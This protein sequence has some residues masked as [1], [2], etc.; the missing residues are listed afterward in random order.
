MRDRIE[1]AF[2][3]W[4]H[5]AYRRAWRVIAIGALVTVA[6]AT[7]LPKLG[8]DTSTEGMFHP[9][10]PIR[11]AYDEFRARFGSDTMILAAVRP[12]RVFDLATLERLRALHEAIEAEVPLLV[13]VTSLVNARETRG[14]GDEL[15]VGELMEE[16]PETAEQVA[17]IERRALANPLYLDNL[18]SRDGRLTVVVIET[19]TYSSARDDAGFEDFGETG[20]PAA[21]PAFLT[22][23]EQSSIV[24][25]LEDVVRRHRAPG[26][27][28]HLAGTQV[29]ADAMQKEMQADMSRFTGLS[30]GMI[31]AFLA[32]LFRRLAGV[33][34]P[35]AAV[36]LSVVST[37]SI[38]AAIGVPITLPTQILPSFLLAV[39]V[40]ASVHILAI[41]F[42][43]RR[44]GE[45]KQAAIA[46]SLGHSGL[47][48]AMTSLTTAAGVASFVAADLRPISH[49]GW[50][51][52][53]GVL[54]AFAFTVAL[55]PALIAVFPIRDEP[56]GA[57]KS[58]VSQRA[59]VR[60][61]DFATRH[62]VGTTAVWAVILAVALLGATRLRLSHS[63]YEWFPR[64]HPVREA[65]D[66]M[67]A[68]MRGTLF[69]EFLVD[70]GRENGLHDPELLR[71][72]DAIAADAAG[73]RMGDMYVGK[74]LSLVDV[75]EEI[76]QALNENRREFR[77]VPADRE[78]VAQELLLF[79]SA[80]SDDLEDFVDPSFSVGRITMKLPF[81]DAYYLSPVY[82]VLR[83]SVTDRLGGRAEFT[84]TGLG[85]LAGETIR[86]VMHSMVWSYLIA[87]GVICP[88]L[89][90]L[91]GNLRFGLMAIIPNLTPILLTLGVM[92]WAGL[93]LDTFTM[94][95]G[96][97]AIGLAVD[98]T[99]HFM[100]NFR[101][102]Y[103][104]SGDAAEAV[105]ETLAS[106]GQAMLFTSLVLST[107]FSIYAFAD[108]T[109]LHNFG[110]LTAFTIVT[111][112]LADVIL[113]PALMVLAA[114]RASRAR[115]G[116]AP[117]PMEVS[118]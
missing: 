64:G 27:E 62:A 19:S 40:G 14:V 30:L 22:G 67:N 57:K 100:H 54:L 46:F 51:A 82:R 102:Y 39:G 49:L 15:V 76:H 89:V 43:A 41:F 55:L 25:A 36:I 6:L 112:F 38:M 104:R 18:I 44:R 108:M 13:E 98:D 56:A 80:G 88:L 10:D 53:L 101:R 24:E 7:Q 60:I 118:Q 97:I 16:W 92:G 94:M 113:S 31:T 20:A 42:Q 96:S 79:E 78:L 21:A 75:V 11:V 12:E 81:L 28:I 111:A 86:A 59:L 45:N 17:E 99:I 47:A 114:R 52:P 23:E 105:R 77:T 37:M 110:L 2:E 9:D 34:L 58:F 8:F 69:I 91:T 84:L 1:R 32:L 73:L 5:L 106:T 72:M 115:G 48:V 85:V 65:S 70:A 50:L 109:V 90:L 93:G 35:L 63:P 68:E 116:V 103:A 83:E 33:V 71:G 74:T 66:L 26:F 87:F 29:M 117:A 3:A 4:G 61:G 95:I 107:G